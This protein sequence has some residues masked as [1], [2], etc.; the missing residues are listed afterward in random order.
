MRNRRNHVNLSALPA[1]LGRLSPWGA[2]DSPKS[3]RR[4]RKVVLLFLLGV[5]VGAAMGCGRIPDDGEPVPVKDSGTP[6]PSVSTRVETTPP[7][8]S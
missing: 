6:E 1:R 3:R 5:T 4:H 7:R 8:Q 2:R